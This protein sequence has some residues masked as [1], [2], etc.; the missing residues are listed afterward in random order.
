[1]NKSGKITISSR[2]FMSASIA[3]NYICKLSRDSY[4]YKGKW[5]GIEETPSHAVGRLYHVS[6]AEGER[7]YL[8][9][10]LHHVTGATSSQDVR[11]H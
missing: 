11:T 3:D 2:D 9:L 4:L 8:R 7:F 1:V 10:L 6:P 5:L